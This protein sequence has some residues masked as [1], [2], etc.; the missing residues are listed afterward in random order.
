MEACLLL[1]LIDC[2]YWLYWKLIILGSVL[3]PTGCCLVLFC[4]VFGMWSMMVIPGMLGLGR[5]WVPTIHIY[6][7]ACTFLKS[8]VCI[9]DAQHYM[10]YTC[11][12]TYKQTCSY[13]A[14]TNSHTTHIST[15]YSPVHTHSSMCTYTLMCEFKHS[16]IHSFMHVLHTHTRVQLKNSFVRITYSHTYSNTHIFIFVCFLFFN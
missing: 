15:V 8:Y 3:F 4:F 14:R 2:L 7:Y 10:K 6:V 1:N 5:A 9:S 16:H 11:I 13:Q 12:H